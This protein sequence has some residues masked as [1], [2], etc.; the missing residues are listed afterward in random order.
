MATPENGLA[1]F[2]TSPPPGVATVTGWAALGCEEAA[3]MDIGMVLGMVKLRFCVLTFT[4][5]GRME[6]TTVGKDS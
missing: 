3:G 1:N 5:L 4:T 6:R 2:S